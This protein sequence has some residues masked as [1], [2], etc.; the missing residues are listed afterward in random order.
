MEAATQKVY[1]SR[2][3]IDKYLEKNEYHEESKLTNNSDE[4]SEVEVFSD[5]LDETIDSSKKT[6]IQQLPAKRKRE[7]VD[8]CSEN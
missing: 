1:I 2:R 6:L 4:Y 3:H 8:A 7:E 5:D